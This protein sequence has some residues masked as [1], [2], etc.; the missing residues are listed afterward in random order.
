MHICLVLLHISMQKYA[1][2]GPPLCMFPTLA[3]FVYAKH[4]RVTKLIPLILV[5]LNHPIKNVIGWSKYAYLSN[6]NVNI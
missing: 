3:A 4:L 6:V 5:A 2:A 1:S